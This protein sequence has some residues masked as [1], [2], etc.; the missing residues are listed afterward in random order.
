MQDVGRD[1]RAL[2]PSDLMKEMGTATWQTTRTVPHL[3][4]SGD[5]AVAEGDISPSGFRPRPSH[6]VVETTFNLKRSLRWAIVPPIIHLAEPQGIEVKKEWGYSVTR[7]TSMEKSLEVGASV[8]GE[9]GLGAFKLKADVKAA[10][11][12]TD[13]T[14]EEWT[15]RHEEK[16][17]QEFKANV[18]YVTWNLIDRL[19]LDKTVVERLYAD[20][21]TEPWGPPTTTKYSDFID[22]MVSYWQDKLPPDRHP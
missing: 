5:R 21:P 4:S 12:I 17:T 20:N 3:E 14:T 9:T 19:E 2:P 1:V 18:T 6:S 22:C 15:E 7:Q 13:S 10:L 16:K 8:G 11:K